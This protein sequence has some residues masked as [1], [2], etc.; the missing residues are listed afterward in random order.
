MIKFKHGNPAWF[1]FLVRVLPFLINC[2]RE[3]FCKVSLADEHPDKPWESIC[4]GRFD[5]LKN[6]EIQK[7]GCHNLI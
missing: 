1:C 5:P 7:Q 4:Q 2:G 3:K 6:L